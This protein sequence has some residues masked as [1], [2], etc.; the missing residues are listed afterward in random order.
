MVRKNVADF[1]S[2]M[3]ALPTKIAGRPCFSVM[4][5]L[6]E[7]EL[8]HESYIFYHWAIVFIATFSFLRVEKQSQ[9]VAEAL[10]QFKALLPTFRDNS[11]PETYVP[12]LD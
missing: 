9:E 1:A 6:E 11:A 4:R 3:G 2:K 7:D 8:V 12:K 10:A 5:D